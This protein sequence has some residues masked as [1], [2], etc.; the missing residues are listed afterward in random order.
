MTKK[1]VP[2]DY[3]NR[4]FD[5][6]REALENFTKR[7]YPNTYR[8]FNQASFGSLMLDTVAYVGDILSFY[9]DYQVNESFLD[10]AIE[11]SNV[12]RIAR[13][14]GFKSSTNPSSHGILTFY[15]EIPSSTTGLGPDTS[16]N[17]I[18]QAGSVFGSSGGGM[19]TLLDDVDFT[20]RAAQIVVG[21][22]DPTTGN[23][24]TYVV[25]AVGRAVSGRGGVTRI[26]L[27]SFKRFRR[28][29]LG[30]INLSD[31]IKVTDIEG[32][33]YFEVDN[34][35][36]NIIYKAVRNTTATRSTVPNILK[37]VPVA[38]RYV[39]ETVDGETFLQFGYGSTDNNLTNP[40]VDPTEVVLD[41][42]GRNYTTD[43]EFDPTKLIS[44]D[45]FGIAP[46][47]TTLIIEYRFNTTQDVNTA[48]NTISD[49]IEGNFKFA[50][51]GALSPVKRDVVI[52]S[53]EVSNENP[54]VGDVS[55][56]SSEEIKQRAYGYFATQN[57]AV[58][59]Q[60]YQALT[61][62]MPAKYGA[63]KRCAVGKDA[64]E[65]KRNINLYVISET[66]TGK[67]TLANVTLKTNLKNWLLQH[68]MISDTIDILD[69]RIVNYTLHYEVMPTLNSNRF[70]VINQCNRAV[71]KEFTTI[72]DIGEP[73]LLSDLY[74]VLQPVPGVLDVISVEARLA[75]GALYSVS[76]YD[77]DAALSADG[78]MVLAD[79]N[80]IFELKY[81]N[82]DIK[83]SVR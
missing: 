30:K 2:I 44:T 22:S 57:R 71:A 62:S 10:S 70:E 40:V 26:E 34:L 18:L 6:I 13:Q 52:G 82:L 11:Y 38:R 21:S 69:A 49:V 72:L 20:G 31:I 43:L 16:L 55:L 76:S 77:F 37:A 50:N 12:Q 41:L 33:E 60:D 17:P 35:S 24:L 9:L 74:R 78:R 25:R 58:T 73:L 47:D 66:S 15:I 67:L 61:Y 80:V 64:D 83:G 4:D 3:T 5:S 54:F 14:L 65:F 63:I 68:K 79:K 48:T 56:P 19:Y 39:L 45:K 23:V 1:I 36:Q 7:Y 81:P 29:S 32:N 27:G 59:A 46:S 75:D 8:D 28:V 42:S 53:L 51:Q